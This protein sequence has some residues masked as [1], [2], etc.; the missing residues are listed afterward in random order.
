MTVSK[1]LL[2][3]FAAMMTANAA[4]AQDDTKGADKDPFADVLPENILTLDDGERLD[5]TDGGY[6]TFAMNA[7]AGA[8]LTLL[9]KDMDRYWQ[10]ARQRFV[11]RTIEAEYNGDNDEQKAEALAEFDAAQENWEAFRKAQCNS[12]F[13]EWRDGT[14]RG[15]MY[16]T[17]KMDAVKMRMHQIWSTWLTYPDSTPPILPEPEFENSFMARR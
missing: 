2:G 7:C 13:Y 16:L 15:I 6:T 14:I 1:I 9:E 12:V 11:G 8:R 4:L 10:A 5:C 17:C 3:I